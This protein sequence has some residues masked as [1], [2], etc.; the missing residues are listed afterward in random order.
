[1]LC[2]LACFV[3]A[4]LPLQTHAASE[5][6]FKSEILLDEATGLT[7]EQRTIFPIACGGDEELIQ[8]Y[9]QIVLDPVGQN[10]LLIENVT[11][12]YTFMHRYRR[13]NRTR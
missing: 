2:L 13:T 12:Q 10:L 3:P 8:Q 4:S 1:M 7:L 9:T 6:M 11:K 5:A